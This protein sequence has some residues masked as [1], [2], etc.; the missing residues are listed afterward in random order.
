M[1]AILLLGFVCPVPV[2]FAPACFICPHTR[3]GCLKGWLGKAVQ[4]RADQEGGRQPY[5]VLVEELAGLVQTE[6]GE[7]DVVRTSFD[8]EVLSVKNGYI[9]ATRRRKGVEE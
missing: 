4:K 1:N 6:C 5:A 7:R 8:P 2:P 3:T 9:F